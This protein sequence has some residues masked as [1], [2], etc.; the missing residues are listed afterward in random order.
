MAYRHFRRDDREQHRQIQSD[1]VHLVDLCR[2]GMLY[3]AEA[4]LAAG[5]SPL[6][7]PEAHSCPLQ[8]ATEKGFHSLVKLLPRHGCAREQMADA[9]EEA[10]KVGN[11][12]I[13]QLLVE[14]GAPVE[15]LPY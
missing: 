2:P 6:R 7:P 15:E 1:Y 4:W 11:M 9:L 5:H 12:E 14:A 8:I 13:C 10:A 3:E